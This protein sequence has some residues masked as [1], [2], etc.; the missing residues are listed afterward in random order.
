MVLIMRKVF[1][2]LISLLILCGCSDDATSTFSNREHVYCALDVLQSDV[3][4]NVMGNYGQFA[5]VRKRV[6]DGKTQI[7]LVS[8]SGLKGYYPLNQLSDNYGFGL[9]GLIVGTSNFGEA[10]CYDL[11]CH[12]CDRAN[13]RLSFT[14][15]GY[16][17]C[18]KCG[19]T[20]DLKSS[21]S[22]PCAP[23]PNSSTKTTTKNFIASSSTAYC[24]CAASTTRALENAR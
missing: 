7:E 20:F 10:L 8:S 13:R 9:G 16:A 4:F 18:G 15:N 2:T 24:T 14:N 23:T 3:L 19:V 22:T 6:V 5:S 21:H 11:S 17:K 1:I 12:I